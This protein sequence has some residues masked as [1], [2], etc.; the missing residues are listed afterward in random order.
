[1]DLHSARGR[2]GIARQLG[3]I[4]VDAG[5]I[6]AAITDRQ[7][8]GYVKDDGSPCSAADMASERLIVERLR[9]AFPGVPIVA[10]EAGAEAHEGHPFFLVD[11]LDGTRDYLSGAGEYSVNI[12][13][14]LGDRPVA[15][16]VAAPANGRVWIA[17]D[18]ALVGAV[19][20]TGEVETW[21]PARVRREPAAGLVALVSRRHGDPETEAVLAAL[22]VGE[23]RTASSAYKFCLI[24][25]GE[26]DLY[27]RC[28]PTME[29][30]TAAGDHVVAMAGGVTLGADKMPLTYGHRGRRYLNGAFVV[31]GDPALAANLVLPQPPTS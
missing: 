19:P 10:E 1:M 31:L 13:L 4:A 24:A 21:A 12:A 11:P 17:G 18:A 27:V 23:R 14:V 8:G 28:G 26:A 2:D 29:W 20:A 7:V 6:L 25:S 15:A 3:Q 5:R 9:A 30:D 22:R 16:A